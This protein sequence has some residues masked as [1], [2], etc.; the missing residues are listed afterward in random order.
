MRARALGIMTAAMLALALP[1]AA[2]AQSAPYVDWPALLPPLPAPHTPVTVPD[3]ASGSPQCI[4]DTIVEMRRRMNTVVPVCDHRVVFSLAY[5]RVTEDVR[6]AINAGVFTDRTWLAQEDAY[7]ARLYFE[8]YDR[9][10]A[11]Q[12]A[13]IPV[14]WRIA[15]DAA[16]DRKVTA[17]G[18]FLL[19]MNAHINRDMPHVLAAIGIT[20]PDGTSRKRDHDVYNRR[21]AALYAPVLKEVADRF[22]PSADNVELGP[23]DDEA[24]YTILQSWR[25]GVWRNAERLVTARTPAAR[26]QVAQS[27]ELY[28]Q[29]VGTFI[30]T[31]TGANPA[32]RDAWCATHG[33][34]QP[35]ARATA[36]AKARARARAKA[37]RAR[38]HRARAHRPT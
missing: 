8:A 23:L 30:R 4:E 16:R 21:L 20:R 1:A 19:A 26:A 10:A 11:G 7:F 14:A 18:D 13:A 25:E 32:K 35:S 37:K 6:D 5:L 29:T 2:H 17:L 36:K 38:T 28:A 12:R 15:F 3:C 33:G 34:Q 31:A 9:Y 24:A 22:D 27:I